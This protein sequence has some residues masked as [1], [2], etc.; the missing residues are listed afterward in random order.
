[1]TTTSRVSPP[2]PLMRTFRRILR[3]PYSALRFLTLPWGT[4]VAFLHPRVGSDYAIGKIAKL[5]LL[6]RLWS[7]SRQP[8]SASVFFEHV[9]IVARLLEVPRNTAGAVAEFGCYKGL[10]TASLSL[11][12]ALN[13][14]RL[15]VF[16]S[17]EGL[18]EPEES[19]RHL[20]SGSAVPY[21]RGQYMGTL[22]EVEC[23]VSRFGDI[24]VCEFVKGYLEDTLPNRDPEER[25]VLIFEDADLPQSVRSVLRGAWKRLQADCVFFCHE[26]R[27]Q[28][29]VN[30][31]FDQGWWAQAI[32][33]LAP[34]FIGSGVGVVSGLGL[35]WCCLG[36]A[37]RRIGVTGPFEKVNPQR[38]AGV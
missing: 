31:F 6:R 36:F 20:T 5:R 13:H 37:V 15:I 26:A 27:D 25:F 12:C 8:G 18:P 29:V 28:E 9:Y 4:A 10:S 32:G 23:N 1:M 3:A 33:E 24:G 22:E 2:F 21:H 16:D 19:V 30:L 34:G 17:F 7:N 11:A 38:D 35:D 14:R